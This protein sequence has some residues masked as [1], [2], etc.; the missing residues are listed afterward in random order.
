M[1]RRAMRALLLMVVLLGAVL[2]TPV[3]ANGDTETY[4]ITGHVLLEGHGASFRRSRGRFS[5]AHGC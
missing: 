2:S 5:S 1:E 3:A 4:T